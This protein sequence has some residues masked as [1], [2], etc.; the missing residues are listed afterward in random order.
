MS[1]LRSAGGGAICLALF[2]C[3]VCSRDLLSAGM[4]KGIVETQQA[5]R[6][7]VF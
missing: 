3:V 5:R 1:R 2:R 7:R 6:L 4:E